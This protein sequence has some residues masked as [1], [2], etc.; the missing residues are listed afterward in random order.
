MSASR[1][2]P[3]A[4]VVPWDDA[5]T[6]YDRAHFVLYMRLIDAK[7]SGA[8]LAEMAHVLFEIDAEA[9]PE[10]ARLA[11]ESH[12]ARARWM[13]EVGYRLLLQERDG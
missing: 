10:R 6:D 5:L 8:T 9:E 12:L 7:D 13:T 2:I 1:T 3:T 4:A 11:V